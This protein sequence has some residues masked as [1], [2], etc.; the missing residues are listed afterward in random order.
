MVTNLTIG[1]YPF[2][3]VLLPEADFSDVAAVYV[4]SCVASDGGSTV[5]DV[6]Q[7]TELGTKNGFA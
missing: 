6:G 2:V 4:I 1:R 3:C 5:L 7:T